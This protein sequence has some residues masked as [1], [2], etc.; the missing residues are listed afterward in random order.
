MIL[1]RASKNDIPQLKQ[2]WSQI[3]NSP[4]TFIN[5]FFETRW[6][7][8]HCYIAKDN[9]K[10]V[11]MLHCLQ[12]SYTR[13]MN[14]TNISYI[15]GAATLTEYRKQGLLTSLLDLSHKEEQQ[16]L[17]L[18]SNFNPFF[19]RHGFFYTSQNVCYPIE[20]LGKN[21]IIN[22]TEDIASIYINATEKTGSLDRDSFAW[23]LLRENCKTIVVEENYQR[24]YALVIDD[25]AFETMCEGI[26]SARA[27]KRKMENLNISQVWMPS[28]SPLAYLFNT[29]PNF[30][31]LG[32]SNEKNICSGIY[33]P[34]QF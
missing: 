16:I 31:P 32:M 10:I 34:Q 9:N 29:P 14:T 33:I 8:D 12:F 20:S 30:I 18:N 25:V 19:E 5:N 26:D 27:L 22:Q 2:M 23:K 3:F 1:T 7:M 11:S 28:N 17:T 13:E 24:A 4:K 15:V 21:E 6:D